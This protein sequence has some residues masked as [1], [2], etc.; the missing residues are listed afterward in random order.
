MAGWW[1]EQGDE[2]HTQ[3]QGAQPWALKR[4]HG[5]R[6]TLRH[7]ADGHYYAIMVSKCMV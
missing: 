5:P 7:Q 2:I 4:K 1:T 6:G 3:A